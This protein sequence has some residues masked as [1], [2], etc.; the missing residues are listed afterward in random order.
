[1]LQQYRRFRVIQGL[2]KHE[3]TPLVL[4]PTMG[5]ISE[6]GRSYNSKFHPG[7]FL[8]FHPLGAIV[9]GTIAAG[10]VSGL[11][12]SATL[13]VGTT[14]GTVAAGD[15]PRFG[16]GANT[17]FY[18]AGTYFTGE[19]IT[20]NLANGTNQRIGIAS[21]D[22]TIALDSV[23][24]S[25]RNSSALMGYPSKSGSTPCTTWPTPST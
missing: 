1:M 9:T 19:T 7:L 12:N 3:T 17:A 14:A 25:A 8:K 4:L 22:I 5:L 21:S 20:L 15:D 24:N 18:N 23:G 6:G 13:D 2:F 10:S 16:A 11:G